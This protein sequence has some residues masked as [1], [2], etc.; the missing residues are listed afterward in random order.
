MNGPIATAFSLIA[1]GDAALMQIIGL[2]LRVTLSAVLVAC[3]VGLPLG[4]AL[5]LGRFAGPQTRRPAPS[6][7]VI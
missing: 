1:S 7:R 4:A 2:P 6:S 5:A 3:V